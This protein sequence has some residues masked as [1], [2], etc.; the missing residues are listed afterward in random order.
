CGLRVPLA[1]AL[2]PRAPPSIPIGSRASLLARARFIDR[3]GSSPHRRSIKPSNRGIGLHGVR[4]LDKV[5]AP[6]PARVTIGHNADA[7]YLAIRVKELA[8]LFFG[9]RK[10]QIPNKD[11]HGALLHCSRLSSTPCLSITAG[12][13]SPYP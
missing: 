11:I 1:P 6:G 3:Q 12:V 5:K 7:C 13:F 9:G 10:G 8:Q 4:H 2:P